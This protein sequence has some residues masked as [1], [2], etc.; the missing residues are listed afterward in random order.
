MSARP[1][2]AAAARGRA[3]AAARGRAAAAAARFVAGTSI[4]AAA[5]GRAARTNP[6][7]R[8]ALAPE[9]EGS[10]IDSDD[11]PAGGAFGILVRTHGLSFILRVFLVIMPGSSL[12]VPR[13]SQRDTGR[14]HASPKTTIRTGHNSTLEMDPLSY[15]W[16]L[17]R[18]SSTSGAVTNSACWFLSTLYVEDFFC[19]LG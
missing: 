8:P 10:Q 2:R 7:H 6:G 18:L 12:A 5:R 17:K 14:L 15:R 3:A 13:H 9:T 4:A 1:P 19:L 16:S 11:E